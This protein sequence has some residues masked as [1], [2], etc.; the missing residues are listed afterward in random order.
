[1]NSFVWIKEK[2]DE[3]NL[4]MPSINEE[5]SYGTINNAMEE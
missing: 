3:M 4:C 5:N 2:N 1:M